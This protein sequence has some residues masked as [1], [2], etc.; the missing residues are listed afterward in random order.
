MIGEAMG[1]KFIVK[2]KRTEGRG[3]GFAECGED[4]GQKTVMRYTWIRA[5]VCDRGSST[6]ARCPKLD[7]REVILHGATRVIVNLALFLFPGSTDRCLVMY[8]SIETFAPKLCGARLQ[9]AP[10]KLTQRGSD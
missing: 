4:A 1:V 9:P 6:R 5:A 3:S 10:R 2:I 7:L 8:D